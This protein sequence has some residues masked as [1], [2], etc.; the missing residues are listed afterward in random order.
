MSGYLLR[1]NAPLEALNTLRVASRAALLADV[2]SDAGLAELLAQPYLQQQPVMM[3]GEGSNLLFIGDYDGVILRLG[4]A[5]IDIIEQEGSRF[6]VSVA[7]GERWDDL[8]RWSVGRG[9]YGLE[10]LALIPGSVGAAPIQNIGAYGAELAQTLAWVDAFDRHHNT[11]IRL[12]AEQCKFSYRDSL[13][14]Q[15]PGRWIVT[16][17]AFDLH[18]QGELKLDYAGVRE[19]L[20]Q[21]GVDAPRPLHAAEVISRIRVRK[22]PNPMLLPNAGSFFKNP[23]VPV[24]QAEAIAAEHHDVP[25]FAASDGHTKLSAAWLIE[26][27]GMRGV[28]E[29]DA[30]IAEQH[31]L[32]LVNHGRASGEQLLN[33]A[34]RVAETVD[35]RFGV[36][37][38][39]EVRLI[40]ATW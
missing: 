19:E 7:G 32:V 4:S 22:L 11:Q 27:S 3:I 37:L 17:V 29:G 13:F 21:L 39:P 9:L 40:G 14:K 2:R 16:R 8:V 36:R 6:R 30:G 34:R 33:L 26:R 28:R 23:E 31:A 25:R 35:Q 1:E 15:Q 10:N 12:N 5:G 20:A 24:A 18:D 38:E